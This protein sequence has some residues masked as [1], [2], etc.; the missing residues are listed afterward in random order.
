VALVSDAGTPLV[1][2][3]GYRVVA[4]ALAAGLPVTSLPGP[5]AFVTAL[6]A[7]GL[8]VNQFLFL[9]FPPRAASARRAFFARVAQEPATLA[10]YEAPHRLL[11]T[12]S[13]ASDALGERAACLAR[14]LTKRHESY[15]R[16]SLRDLHAALAVEDEVRGEAT[17]IIAGAPPDAGHAER[18]ESASDDVRQLLA[19]GLDGKA[20]LERVMQTHGL[21][22]REVYALILV[23]KRGDDDR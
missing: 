3:P 4:A 16:G 22:R 12:L 1:S 2:D 10:L 11:E 17:L 9:G 19:A 7:C 14:N 18:V 23:A 21:G 6:A 5:C 15:Q 13:V 20:V 8:P